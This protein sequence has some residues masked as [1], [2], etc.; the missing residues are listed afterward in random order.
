MRR[1]LAGAHRDGRRLTAV[2]DE[3]HAHGMR[4][5]RHRL[6]QVAAVHAAHGPLAT[7]IEREL[8]A[9]DRRTALV[10]DTTRDGARRARDLRAATTGGAK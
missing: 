2:A 5:G 3:P 6:D 1:A 7:L 10:S 8:R 4:A 9:G